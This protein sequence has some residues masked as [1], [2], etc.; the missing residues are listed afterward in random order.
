M[1]REF[2][3][4]NGASEDQAD[5]VCESIILHQDVWIQSGN[6][7]LNGQMII[8]ATCVHSSCSCCHHV[9]PFTLRPMYLA[10]LSSLPLMVSMARWCNITQ[11]NG[12]YAADDISLFDNAGK[13]PE[14]VHQDTIKSICEAHPR[15]GWSEKF[16]C[17]V[18]KEMRLVHPSKC[19]DM[20]CHAPRRFR[21]IGLLRTSWSFSAW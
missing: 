6:I 9:Q 11:L 7:S 15:Q 10:M 4:E 13:F 19:L 14:Y 8:L 18:E 12:E 3:L 16:A 2:L 1:A 5:S 20:S 21:F 17:A